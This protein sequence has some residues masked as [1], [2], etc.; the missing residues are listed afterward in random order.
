MA[1]VQQN[2]SKVQ[3]GQPYS[4]DNFAAPLGDPSN[5]LKYK[6]TGP[7]PYGVNSD[8]VD[9]GNTGAQSPEQKRALIAQYYQTGQLPSGAS[10]M[11]GSSGF[12]SLPGFSSTTGG[13]GGIPAMTPIPAGFSTVPGA[14]GGAGYSGASNAD[15]ATADF[16]SS[17]KS[18]LAQLQGQENAPVTPSA[19]RAID[20][21]SQNISDAAQAQ[22]KRVREQNAAAGLSS[23]Q[24]IGSGKERAVEE[25]AQT[26]SAKAAADISLQRERDQDALNLARAGQ[27]NSLY[28]QYGTASLMPWQQQMQAQQLALQG[29]QAQDQ[30]ALARAGLAQQGQISQAQLAASAAAQQQAQQLALWNAMMSG[31]GGF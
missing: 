8:L 15:P 19:Q 3:Q 4:V 29:W 11:S 18:R 22:K 13:A 6:W 28:G 26:R 1:V 14:G 7:N 2:P 25:A 16:L 30:S 21:T 27:V 5:P 9:W 24:G 31:L 17:I 10:L 12:T 23:A 20:L